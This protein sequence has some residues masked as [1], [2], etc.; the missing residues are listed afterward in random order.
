MASPPRKDLHLVRELAR[1]AVELAASDEYEARRRR[2][3]DVNERRRPDRAP[4]W[5]R[6]AGAWADILPPESLACTDPHCR[7]V[8]YAFRQHLYKHWVGDD[9]IFEP[10]WGV[11]ARWKTNTEHVW[12]LP[13]GRQIESTP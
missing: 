7:A 8:E 5:C 11:S 3:R 9:H 2:W 4:V 12:G 13:T 6:P 1:G 10:W